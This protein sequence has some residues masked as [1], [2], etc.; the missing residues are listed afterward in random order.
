MQRI[1]RVRALPADQLRGARRGPD[2]DLPVRVSAELAR[3]RGHGSRRDDHPEQR[4]WVERSVVDDADH[5]ERHPVDVDHRLHAD[6]GYSQLPG[7]DGAQHRDP[8]AALVHARVVQAPVV[9]PGADH[10]ERPG[11]GGGDR[12]ADPALLAEPGPGQRVGPVHLVEL[13]AEADLPN[14]PGRDDAV[15]LVKRSLCPLGQVGRLLELVA[16]R[17]RDDGR[18]QGIERVRHRSGGR[19]GEPDG[20]D[21]RAH[22][23]HG[24]HRRK[25][26]A[27]RCSGHREH[28]LPQPV[29]HR[30]PTAL[31]AKLGERRRRCPALASRAA[32]TTAGSPGSPPAPL[33]SHCAPPSAAAC[34]VT[35][36]SSMSSLRGRFSASC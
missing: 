18:A 4:L 10:R 21:R 13:A 8:G 35:T 19:V 33:P 17:E 32:T 24:P 2:H 12:Q 27:H 28:R 5:G 31:H 36:P 15:Q 22:G 16:V 25:D 7:R 20:R 11:G 1:D 6:L 3:H 26:R 29:P 34:S 9:Q 23:Q 14:E 30:Q